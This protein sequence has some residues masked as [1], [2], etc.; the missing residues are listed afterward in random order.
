M[1]TQAHAVERAGREPGRSR[2]WPLIVGRVLLV[3]ALVEAG[4]SG[5]VDMTGRSFL[6]VGPEHFAFDGIIAA[7]AG[8]GFI[9][10][11]TARRLRGG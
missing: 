5:L 6:G 9:V 1:A 2:N 10:D 11:G 7:L 8:I 3:W 4:V